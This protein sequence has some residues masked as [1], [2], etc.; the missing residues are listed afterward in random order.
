MHV[1]D[2]DR[3]VVEKPQ[4]KHPFA[5]VA[6]VVGVLLGGTATYGWYV[7]HETA[8]KERE[9]AVFVFADS[10]QYVDGGSVVLHGRVAS[11]TVTRRVTL[12]NAGPVPVNVRN[13]RADQPGLRVRGVEKQ[14][15]VAPGDTVQADADVEIDCFRGLPLGRFPVTLSVETEDAQTQE[16]AP[17]DVFDGSAWSEQAEIACRGES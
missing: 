4:K 7:Q 10:S 13:L 2:L 12:V 14:R 16:A 15:W 3:P 1:I 17:R 8:A 6:L 5:L 9:V 11:V